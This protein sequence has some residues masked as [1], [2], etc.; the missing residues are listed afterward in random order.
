MRK[1]S[2]HA[3][4]LAGGLLLALILYRIAFPPLPSDHDQILQQLNYSVQAFENR[5][6]GAALRILSDHYIDDNGFTCDAVHILLTKQMHGATAVN[7]DVRS[8]HIDITG[9]SAISTSFVSASV[10]TS[11]G[12]WSRASQEVILTW[13]REHVNHFL[14]VPAK[15]WRIIHAS[16][17][18]IEY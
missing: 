15:E 5:N 4:M 14:V 16:Y 2:K 3:A 18:L 10:D 6:I 13:K 12:T 11:S 17:G 7:I 9:D 8:T 1:S